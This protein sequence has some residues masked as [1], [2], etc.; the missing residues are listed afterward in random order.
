MSAVHL[1]PFAY[2]VFL[3]IVALNE[4]LASDIVVTF[5]LG[6]V[7]LDVVSAALCGV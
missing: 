5:N 2:G 4:R 1:Q 3:V 7:V 6:W